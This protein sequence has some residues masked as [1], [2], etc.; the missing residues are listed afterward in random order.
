MYY[1]ILGRFDN[2]AAN[3]LVFIAQLVEH[4]RFQTQR[5]YVRIPLKP[6]NFAP[7]NSQ[8]LTLLLQL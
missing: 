8:L 5:P 2:Q 1:F 4:L 3:I 6:G 7:V